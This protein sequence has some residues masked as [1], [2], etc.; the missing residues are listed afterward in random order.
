MNVERI[1]QRHRDDALAKQIASS[2]YFTFVAMPFR[3]TFSY[4]SKEIY[5]E[6]IQRAAAVANRKGAAR[7]FDLPRRADEV[8]GQAIVITEEIIVSILE[9]HLFVADITF[10]NAG[11]LLETGVA[12]GLKPN[13]QIILLSQ[14]TPEELHFDLRGRLKNPGSSD[15]SSSSSS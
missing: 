15:S 10:H 13:G 12:L 2:N 4:R 6:V 5:S 8:S 3:D 11:V 14:G 7:K 9:C 1:Y